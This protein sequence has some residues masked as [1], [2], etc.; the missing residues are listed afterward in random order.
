MNTEILEQIGL[1]KSEIKVYL[2]LLELG[3][4][5]TGKI[6]DKSGASSSKI[7]EILD[8]L[9]EKGLVS[10]ILVGGVKQFE[11]SPVERIMEYMKEKEKKFNEQKNE[12]EKI[13][14]GLKMKQQISKFKSEATIYKGFRGVETAFY[15]ALNLLKEGEEHLAFG[16]PKRSEQINSFFIKFNKERARRKI[17]NRIIFTEEARKD[18]I[19]APQTYAKN[20]PLAKI[21]FTNE[22]IPA[23]INIFNNR[24][25][26][27]P[28]EVEKP[29]I[30]V[31][32]NKEIAESF[33]IQFEKWWKQ[34]VNVYKGFE[35]VTNKFWES[36]KEIKPGEEYCVLGA[37]IGKGGEKLQK[38]FWEY[39]RK[40][41]EWGIKVKI[42]S[43]KQDYNQIHNRLIKTGDP[44]M[45]F[46]KIRKMPSTW[47]QPMQI[48]LYNGNK[49]LIFLFG[50][51]MTCFEIESKIIYDNFKYQ[52]DELW[53][54][55][56]E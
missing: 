8:R 41:I 18:P 54:I 55:S 30:I 49:V 14:P 52:F 23:A 44:E 4:S 9:M 48:N 1:T 51:E 25:I 2:A 21:K 13:L 16:I 12:L 26:I 22:I 45:K 36:T 10:F 20:N 15:D 37:T 46:S 6:V 43:T 39:H 31:I 47:K 5:S 27:F 29:L 56:K 34:D 11:A 38:W 35:E 28:S 53:K 7:Y 17:K 42:I 33:K 40:R 50:E 3:S 19:T 32:D 24:V